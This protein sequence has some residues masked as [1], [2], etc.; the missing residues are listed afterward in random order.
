MS[1]Y[2][3]HALERFSEL[4]HQLLTGVSIVGALV[5]PIP[6]ST[7][8]RSRSPRFSHPSHCRR[9]CLTVDTRD[10]QHTVDVCILA[11]ARARACTCVLHGFFAADLPRCAQPTFNRAIDEPVPSSRPA[12]ASACGMAWRGVAWRGVAWH[13]TAH[14]IAPSVVALHVA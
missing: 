13:G 4:G 12:C 6:I 1:N 7:P 5:F 3:V 10:L 9:I 11:R 2:E 8:H 14:G